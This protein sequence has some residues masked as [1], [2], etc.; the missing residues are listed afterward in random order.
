MTESDLTRRTFVA[1]SLAAVGSGFAA[2]TLPLTSAHP[3]TGD[4]R[5]SVL[6]VGGHPDDPESGCGG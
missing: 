5:L 2:A 1:Q 4:A 3:A 6:C